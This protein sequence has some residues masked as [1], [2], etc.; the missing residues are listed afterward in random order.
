MAELK[1]QLNDRSVVEFLAQ[2]PHEKR[3]QDSLII[4]QLMKEVTG[5]APQM[6][7]DSLVGFGRYEYKYASGHAGSWFITGFSPRKQ[8]LT[9][10]IMAGFDQ[11]DALMARLGKHKT[12]KSCLY[13][14]KI[15]DVDLAVLRE[16]VAL[17]VAHMKAENG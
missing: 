14:N 16:L 15:E 12:G 2:V 4:L 11:Y 7:G 5:E 1:T 6:W 8:N 17:S 13:I 9:L 10:Y 3:R